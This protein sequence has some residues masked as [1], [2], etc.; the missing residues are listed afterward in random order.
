M[1]LTAK[2]PGEK[3]SIISVNYNQPDVTQELLDSIFTTNTYLNT[4]VIIVDNGSRENFI[5]IWKDRYP[6]VKFIHSEENLGFAG[7]NNLGIAAAD[8]DYLFLVNNDT[9]FTSGLLETLSGT[10]QDFPD[11][12]IVCPKI[13]YFEHP[14]KIQYVGFTELTS[15]TARNQC[16]GQFEDDRGQYDDRVYI[17]AFAHGAA[18]MVS[19]K[20][21]QR[22]GLMA[23]NFFLYY[24]EMDWS[25]RIRKAGFKIRVNTSALIY[26]KES[27]SVGADSPLKIYYMNRNRILLVRKHSVFY[28]QILFFLYFGLMVFPRNLLQFL[29][30]GKFKHI[31]AMCKAVYWNLTHSTNSF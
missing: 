10:F 22:A 28:K 31:T 18:M 23:E 5:P 16:L 9:E 8:G 20:V 4:E 25:L 7:G 30:R 27:V 2:K 6:Q 19:R 12:G 1:N 11:T 14:G 21:F 13:N 24:E 29:I 15:I 3:I 17:T 26:H